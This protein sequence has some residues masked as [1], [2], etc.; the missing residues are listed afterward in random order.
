MSPR[1][2]PW[3]WGAAFTAALSGI[4]FAGSQVWSLS[5]RVTALEAHRDGDVGKLDH[6]QSQV[7]KLVEWALGHK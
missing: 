5:T 4:G 7:D 3:W 2:H 1:K 6:I